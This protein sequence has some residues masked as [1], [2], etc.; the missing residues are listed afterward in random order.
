[1]HATQSFYSTYRGFIRGKTRIAMAWVFVLILGF[2]SKDLGSVRHFDLVQI[3]CLIIAL[4]GA[5]L[6]YWASGYLRKDTRPAVGGPYAFVR[7]P[8]Y[9]GTYLMAIGFI[10]LTKDVW[11]LMICSA[12]FAAVYHYIILDEETKLDAIFG[13]PYQIYKQTVPRFF[14]RLWPAS[15][16]DLTSVNPE[17]AHRKFSA[18]TARK[19]KAHEAYVSFFGLWF[20]MHF[21]A[22]LWTFTIR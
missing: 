11:F 12:S 18:E 1:M 3:S 9:L 20:W 10:A 5:T 2:F 22:W 21:C 8:L 15:N 16:N 14:P 4:A 13:Q 19:N 7:N 6:R 17:T